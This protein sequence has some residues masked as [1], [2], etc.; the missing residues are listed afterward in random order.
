MNSPTTQYYVAK[1]GQT[2]GPYTEET[3]CQCLKEGRLAQGDYV[4]HPEKLEWVSI[5]A[6]TFLNVIPETPLPALPPL[7]AN[8]PLVVVRTPQRQTAS[9]ASAPAPVSHD[10][11]ASGACPLCN[12]EITRS[13]ILY[14][15]PVC[16]KCVNSFVGKRQF[17]WFLDS[18]VIYFLWLGIAASTSLSDAYPLVT[19]IVGWI[20]IFT[21]FSL[22]DS[23]S[24]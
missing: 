18:A 21:F 12:G 14:G 13:K 24:G 1:D 4:L 22:K 8:P 17:A 20:F 11:G 6:A 9:R 5:E 15:K 2:L 16:K 23:I 3:I 10:L 19:Q 7:P